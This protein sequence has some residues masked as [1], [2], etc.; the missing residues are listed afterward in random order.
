MR[1]NL[2]EISK[3]IVHADGCDGNDYT[4]CGLTAENILSSI[5]EYDPENESEIVPSLLKSNKKINCASCM[6]IIRYCHKIPLS[7]LSKEEKD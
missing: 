6:A 2:L 3:G 4:L 7:A 5:K 1:T